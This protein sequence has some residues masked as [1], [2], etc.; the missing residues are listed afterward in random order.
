MTAVTS[1]VNLVVGYRY[2]LDGNR[3]KLFYTDTTAVT[4]SFDNADRLQSLQDWTSRTTSYQYFADGHLKLT[5]NVNG[6]TATVSED[7]AQRL[8]QMWNQTS[9]EATISQHTYTLDSVRTRTAVNETLAQ[10]GGGTN[11]N[12]VTYGFDKLYRL[13][14]DGSTSY[15]YD[16]VGNRLTK[17][18]TTYTYD[19]AD[20]I[21]MAG[22]T[23]YTVNANGN[24]TNRGSDSFTYD[25][26]NRLKTATVSGTTTTN[27]YD[28]DGKRTSQ[29]VG[30]TTTSYVYD[31]GAG[32]PNVLS[33]GARKYVYGLGLAYTV[34]TSN[35]VQVYQIDGLGSVRALTD[36]SGSVVQTYLTDAFEVIMAS[37]IVFPK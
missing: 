11:T 25:Q 13:A 28:G 24:T 29:T 16:P 4:Y 15:T 19:R 33:D 22:S 14:A 21:S 37:A 10:V 30:N 1:P 12:N 20:R 18:S 32:L 35:N 6:T 26:A 5:T 3:R 2:D 17:G 27:T 8:T 34:D 36:S 7:N 31:V 23:S 9:T